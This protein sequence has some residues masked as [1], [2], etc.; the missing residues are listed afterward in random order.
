MKGGEKGRKQGDK[1]T[2]RRC[3]KTIRDEE[4]EEGE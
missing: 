4:D 1:R 2:G 3:G